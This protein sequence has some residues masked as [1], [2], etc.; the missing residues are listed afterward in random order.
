MPPKRLKRSSN[1]DLPFRHSPEERKERSESLSETAG[2]RRQDAIGVDT[3]SSVEPQDRR[4]RDETSR[5]GGKS[6]E[7]RHA[8]RF[9]FASLN[10][11]MK[12]ARSRS[13]G[14][15]SAK[16]CLLL[17]DRRWYRQTCCL[18][19]SGRRQRNGPSYSRRRQEAPS[20]HRHDMP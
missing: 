11:T 1:A 17:P 7:K 6:Y 20:S 18:R 9:L 13:G 2:D 4:Q 10:S 3:L 12:R 16:P 8:H 5:T 14:A 19:S 15:A